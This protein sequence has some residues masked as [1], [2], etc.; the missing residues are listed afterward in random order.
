MDNPHDKLFKNAF[1]KPE[2]ARGLLLSVL[3]SAVCKALDLKDPRPEPGSYL[4]ENLEGRYS[5]LLFS[6]PFQGQAAR[7]KADDASDTT[8]S[9]AFVYVLVEHQSAVDRFMGL[10]L[11]EYMCR[12]WQAFRRDNPKAKRL[13]VVFPLVV[14]HSAKGWTAPV[15]LQDLVDTSHPDPSAVAP[16]IPDFRFLLDDLPRQR[17]EQL[18]ARPLPSFGQLALLI[19]RAAHLNDNQE[20]LAA[21]RAW[22]PVFRALMTD[23]DARNAYRTLFLYTQTVWDIAPKDLGAFASGIG[24]IATEEL[25]TTA[26]RLR[27]EGLEEALLALC[28]NK[29]GGVTESQRKR[30]QS[31]DTLRRALNNILTA[32]RFENLFN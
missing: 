31:C 27:Q 8:A 18:R 2:N 28:S 10:R 9:R 22:I 16:F 26:E 4:D 3:P 1:S 19:L 32:E 11:L 20:I 14:H 29:F 12:I 7:T 6:V 25:M 15:Q 17:T 5:D 30:I 13:P 23:N 21:M 24:K